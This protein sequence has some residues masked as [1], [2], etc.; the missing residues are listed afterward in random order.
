[1]K[2]VDYQ[3]FAWLTSQIRTPPRRRTYNELFDRLHSIEFV[4][5]PSIQHDENRVADALYLR[6]E[7][8]EGENFTPSLVAVSVLEIIV[9]LSR[10]LEFLTSWAADAWAWKLIKNLHLHS[11]YDPLTHHKADILDQTIERLIWRTYEE[12][13]QGGF[14]PLKEPEEDQRQIEIWYQMNAYVIEMNPLGGM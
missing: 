3:Y 14:F 1:M 2:R 12:N 4:V 7:F 9:A 13:G 5:M 6:Q 10:R 11:M 8:A